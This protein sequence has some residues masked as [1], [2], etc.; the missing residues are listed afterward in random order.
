MGYNSKYII[1]NFGTL[2]WT[3]FYTPL[4]YLLLKLLARCGWN[5]WF[6]SLDNVMKK[7]KSNMFYK[8]WIQLVNET[9]LF[10]GTCGAVNLYYLCF[11]TFGN[12]I[13]SLLSAAV[14]LLIFVFPMILARLYLSKTNYDMILR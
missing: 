10:L 5:N 12:A 13:N 9:F 11:N 6:P 4:V 7:A 2:C 1:Q 3:I 14:L 8:A